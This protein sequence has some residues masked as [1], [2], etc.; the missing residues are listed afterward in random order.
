MVKISGIE[1]KK[2]YED[3]FAVKG[4]Y[5]DSA[6]FYKNG[7]YV[8]DFLPFEVVDSDIIEVDGGQVVSYSDATLVIDLSY[9]EFFLDWKKAQFTDT[10]IIEI[11]KSHSA[12]VK[13]FIA[14]LGGSVV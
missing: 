5:V 11:D 1:F 10:F 12:E 8:D 6:K 9:E 2:C 13:A 4:Y 14:S 3:T 7:E